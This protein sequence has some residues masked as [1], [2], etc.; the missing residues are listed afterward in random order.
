MIRG[1]GKDVLDDKTRFVA[2][3]FYRPRDQKYGSFTC[4]ELRIVQEMG[5][6]TDRNDRRMSWDFPDIKLNVAGHVPENLRELTINLHYNDVDLFKAAYSMNKAD[7]LIVD[8]YFGNMSENFKKHGMV[9]NTVS[10]MPRISLPKAKTYKYLHLSTS[11]VLPKTA[12]GSSLLSVNREWRA[13]W[14]DSWME[15]AS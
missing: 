3:S 8:V 10:F 6:S 2:L 9:N 12:L 4:S 11:E 14:D 5:W 1:V 7:Q 13:F 15:M